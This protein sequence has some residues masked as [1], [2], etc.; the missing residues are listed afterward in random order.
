MTRKT[1]SRFVLAFL[2][3]SFM[4][5]AQASVG[6]GTFFKAIYQHWLETGQ[7]ILPT[8]PRTA[9]STASQGVHQT[10]ASARKDASRR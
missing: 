5:T 10:P 1:K 3:L 6:S 7:L 4:S 9:P 8:S 2:C